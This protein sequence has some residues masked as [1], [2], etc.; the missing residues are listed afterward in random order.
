MSS[1]PFQA[2]DSGL[3]LV[4]MEPGRSVSLEEFHEW[5]DT[6]HVPLRIHRFPTFRSATRYAVTSTALHPASG[7]AEVPVAPKS[8]WGAFYTISSNAV[9]GEEA[10][11]SLRSQRSEREAE[12]FTRL[13]IVDRRIYRLEYDSDSDAN[14]RVE[15]KKIGLDV[16]READTPAYLVT[17][18]VDVVPEMV[19]EYNRWFQEEHVPMLANVKGWRRS[20]RFTLIDNGVNG[21]DA[22]QGDAE[23]VPRCLGLHGTLTHPL[24]PSCCTCRDVRTD[25]F[26]LLHSFSLSPACLGRKLAHAPAIHQ[27]VPRCARL[28][29]RQS[30]T[31]AASNRRPSTSAHATRPGAPKSSAPTGATLSGGRGR[32]ASCTALGIPWLPSRRR[33]RNEDLFD[34]FCPCTLGRALPEVQIELELWSFFPK[35]ISEPVIRPAESQKECLTSA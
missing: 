25:T 23:G 15:R 10:Y 7:T 2:S 4:F 22:K 1:S 8:T 27:P 11:T 5:Y 12:L 16:Q 32:R 35:L 18:S 29:R 6:E 28:D 19:E 33:R 24:T 20:R 31:R 3:L 34:P 13:A 17:N 14:I 21:R 9:F 30:T 26:L